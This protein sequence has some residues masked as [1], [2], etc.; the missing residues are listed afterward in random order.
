MTLLVAMFAVAGCVYMLESVFVLNVVLTIP[1]VKGFASFLSEMWSL[2]LRT[3][4]GLTCYGHRVYRF[5]RKV[6]KA[7]VAR[8]DTLHLIRDNKLVMHIKIHRLNLT[9]KSEQI[10]NIKRSIFIKCS[11]FI[12]YKNCTKTA[13]PGI[14]STEAKTVC[15]YAT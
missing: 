9:S 6:W 15:W 5:T 10:E 4:S 2:F 8:F 3:G 13:K 1:S 14:E 12:A 11:L 7:R